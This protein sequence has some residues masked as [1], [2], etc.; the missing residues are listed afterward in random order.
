MR[1]LTL[2]LTLSLTLTLTRYVTLAYTMERTPPFK[3]INV[4]RPLPLAGGNAA[5][6][7]SLAIP[8]AGDKLVVA[9]GVADAESRAFVMS[10]DFLLELF[11]WSRACDAVGDAVGGPP[12]S[13]QQPEARTRE[14]GPTSTES[15]QSQESQQSEQSAWRGLQPDARCMDPTLHSS[16]ACTRRERS[17]IV[18]Y[19]LIALLLAA[20]LNA[21]LVCL[22]AVL[23]AMA[24]MRR[25]DPEDAQRST[26]VSCTPLADANSHSK[27]LPRHPPASA[28]ASPPSAPRTSLFGLFGRVS[29][30]ASPWS[31][32]PPPSRL[33]LEHESS[34]RRA[35]FSPSSS[36]VVTLAHATAREI[37]KA[38]SSRAI[39]QT[40][41][42]RLSDALSLD[43]MQVRRLP[44]AAPC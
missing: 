27:P 18:G 21:L 25:G 35:S 42:L 26:R 5:F 9:Y 23:R 1:A 36:K 40:A 29:Q 11:D 8:P 10:R 41:A 37:W 2:N 4:S 15:Q 44:A 24:S 39:A 30:P 7:S 34:S 12:P 16:D 33:S 38:S 22:V 31:E 13:A 43:D 6:A 20:L 19:A 3:V 32:P 14:G 17:L 28:F